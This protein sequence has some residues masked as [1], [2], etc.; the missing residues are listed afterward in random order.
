M[1]LKRKIIIIF[2][3]IFIIIAFMNSYD[4][5]AL[6]EMS[7]VIAIGFDKSEKNEGNIV[8]TLQIAK[9]EDKESRKS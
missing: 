3:I 6:E 5:N 1:F 8:L 2:S 7:Y 9:P 4:V